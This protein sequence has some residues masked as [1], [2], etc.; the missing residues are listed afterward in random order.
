MK[1][2]FAKIWAVWG[3]LAFV[4]VMLIFFPVFACC[5][6]WKDPRR[7]V[8]A[9]PAFRVW[10]QVYLPL[11]GVRVKT[12][13]KENFEKGKNYIVLCNHNSLMDVPVS[14]PWIP[15]PNK[16]IAKIEM[17][18]IPVFG[19][20]YRIG[21]IL[22]DRK[23]KDSRRKSFVLMKEALDM[24][25]HMCIY[26]EGTRNKTDQPLKEFH[27]GAFKLAV[28]T[29][30]TV[31]PAILM[32]TAKILPNNKSFFLWPGRVDFHF[33]QPIEPGDDAEALKQKVFKLM[34]AYYE[35]NRNTFTAG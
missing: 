6:F 33:L 18:R 2:F 15:G 30:N 14:S 35:A 27:D 28:D 24:G 9:Y 8:I 13:G 22:V 29:G 4:V 34:W 21:S 32:G 1:D 26:P 17:S 12:K 31:L 11:I 23:D 3:M 16:T 25:L 7:S 5:F 10:M 20:I 19:I